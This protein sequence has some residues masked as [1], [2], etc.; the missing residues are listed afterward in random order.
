MKST[1]IAWVYYNRR[2]ELLAQHLGAALHFVCYGEPGKLLQAPVRYG[3]QAVR[4]WRI[5]W[6]EQPNVV[7]V[8]NPPIFCALV[9]ALYARR[10]GARYVIDSHTDAL[11]SSKWGWFLPLH[12]RLSRGAVTTIVT[13][14]HLKEMVHRWGCHAFVL[15]YTPAVY[16]AGERFP[17]NGDFNVAVISTGGEDEP[18]DVVFEAAH[19]LPETSV[20]VTGDSRRLSQDLLAKKPANCHLTG[21]LPYERYIGLLRSVDIV[22]DLTTR[23]H[24]LLLGAFE[25]VSVGTP[26]IVSDWPVLRDYFSRGTVHVPNTVAGLYEGLRRAQC[27][28]PALRRDILLLQAQLHAEWQRKFA[29]LQQL[30]GNSSHATRPGES[31]NESHGDHSNLQ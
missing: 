26:L 1:F 3:V 17:L 5:L 16:P 20:Y 9:A 7:F 23:D 25:A 30:L 22:V 4:T 6:R 31:D 12:R 28:L 18:L 2:S 29:E 19:R 11:I 24:T 27:E 14:E 21:Y 10:Y 15:G 13:N 8:Q